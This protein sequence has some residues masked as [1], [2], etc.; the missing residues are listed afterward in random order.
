MF[1]FQWA[2]FVK[3]RLDISLQTHIYV[4]L[5]TYLGFGFLEAP[6]EQ[7]L[8]GPLL[9]IYWLRLCP[10]FGAPMPEATLLRRRLF[11][12]LMT[13]AH[14]S[15]NAFSL[16]LSLASVYSTS[17]Y[18]MQQCTHTYYTSHLHILYCITLY[19]MIH[20]CPSCIFISSVLPGRL[21]ALGSLCPIHPIWGGCVLG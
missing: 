14:V 16:Q 21:A 2:C 3:G 10:H 9:G 20:Q 5:C 7:F 15:P 1:V 18:N 13:A 12:V 6:P 11:I 4:D 17:Y 19:Y 8:H